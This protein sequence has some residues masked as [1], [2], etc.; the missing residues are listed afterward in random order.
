MSG[1]AQSGAEGPPILAILDEYGDVEA[2]IVRGERFNGPHAPVELLRGVKLRE[3]PEGVYVIPVERIEGDAIYTVNPC[4]FGMC[5]IQLYRDRA[6]LEIMDRG[7]HW[8]FEIGI[9][10]FMDMFRRS[11][12]AVGRATGLIRG[13][14]H[15]IDEDYHFITFT[16]PLDPEM[17]VEQ[18][19]DLLDRL[20]RRVD[21]EMERRI[22]EFYEERLAA[23]RRLTRS[24]RARRGRGRRRAARGAGSRG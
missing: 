3:I 5:W 24:R 20:F 13:V 15:D 16:V 11:L 23:W 22:A 21:E 2:L 10:P 18:A 6:V 17:T 9:G 14:H 8:G 1:A 19:L 4:S 12:R 7:K